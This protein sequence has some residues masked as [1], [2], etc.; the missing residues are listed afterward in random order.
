M[1]D[2]RDSRELQ[3]TILA[4]RGAQRSIRLDINKESRSRIRPLWQQALNARTHDEMTRRIIVPG[5][6]ATATDR[7][8]TMHAATSRRPLSGGLVP[9]FEW[10]GAEFGARS[11][12][13]E[14]TQRSRAG[15]SYR[16]P[17]IINRQF[18]GR[19]QDGMVAFD[20]ASEVGTKLVAMWVH[21]VVDKLN[22]IPA[23]EVTA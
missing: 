6:R 1:L 21:T 12:R 23:V 17:L 9:A 22:E 19:Q 2:V 20:A 8:V 5:A 4:L 14:V 11:R 13:V 10:A 7:G 18:R 3:A 15:R 16:R